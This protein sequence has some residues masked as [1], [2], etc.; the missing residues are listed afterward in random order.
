VICDLGHRKP[1]GVME[2]E[3][4]TL[5]RRKSPKA[6]VQLVTIVDG[7]ELVD[8]GGCVRL[9]QDDI[10]REMPATSR[11]GV[12]GVDEDPMEPRIESIEVAERRELPPHLD[13]GNLDRVLGEVGVAQ[14]PMRDEDAAVTD[15]A[16]QGAEGLLVALSRLVHDRSQHPLPPWLSTPEGAVSKHECGWCG[17]RS[18]SV[19][20]RAD[21]CQVGVTGV[22]PH[23]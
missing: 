10:G 6:A 2:D 12:A 1:E 16:N 13:E 21:N 4:G 22:R 19:C 20:R 9:E 17:N 15:L 8:V 23:L 7:Q 18:M 11:F 14:D 5:L 3:D